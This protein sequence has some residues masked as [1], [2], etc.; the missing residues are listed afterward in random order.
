VVAALAGAAAVMIG[1]WAAGRI[2]GWNPAR[3]RG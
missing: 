2:M 3:W 1:T